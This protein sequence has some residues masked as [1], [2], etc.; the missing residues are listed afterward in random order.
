VA[1]ANTTANPIGVE[2]GISGLKGP[3]GRTMSLAGHSAVMLDL[4][5]FFAGDDA[6]VGGLRVAF[7]GPWGAV[8]VAGGLEDAVKGFSTDLPLISRHFGERDCSWPA[9]I[10]ERRREGE[11]A[12]PAA[13]LPGFD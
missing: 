2:I 8:L 12:G 11:P 4:K 9:P 7:N 3:A 5:D 10:G 1:L 13:E 6:G